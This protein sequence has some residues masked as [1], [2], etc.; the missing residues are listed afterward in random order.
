MFTLPTLP[1]AVDMVGAMVFA[2]TGALVAPR[3]EMD[4]VGFVWLAIITGVGG[5]TVRDLILGAPVF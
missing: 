2:V 1:F 4:I 3:K 5:G